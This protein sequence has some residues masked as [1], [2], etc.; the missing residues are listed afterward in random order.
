[1]GQVTSDPPRR[2]W[3][4]T[5]PAEFSAQSAVLHNAADELQYLLDRGYPAESAAAF[6]GNHHMLSARQ[7]LALTR[8]V[9]SA[10]DAARRRAKQIA[11]AEMR[12]KTVYIDG[13]NTVITLEIAFCRGTLLRC[14]DGTVRDLAGLHGSYSLI[15]ETDAALRAVTE[16]LRG[17]DIAEAVF[18]LDAPVSH[19]GQ[20]R[21]RIMELTRDAPFLTQV[22]LEKAVDY[23]LK[24]AACIVTADAFILDACAGGWFPLTNLAVTQALGAYPYISFCG[25]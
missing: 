12:G 15:P 7:R 20:L 8:A 22:H 14:M 11:P 19:S 25:I 6:V 5:D 21:A 23:H 2:G 24:Q 13:F 1:M 9:C 4:R 10:E 3:L 16:T 18:L 17:L